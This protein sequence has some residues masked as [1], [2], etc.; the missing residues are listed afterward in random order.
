M[1][2]ATRTQT[3]EEWE[4][5]LDAMCRAT[6]TTGGTDP[7]GIGCDL[8]AGHKGAHVITDPFGT[9]TGTW[10]WSF[11]SRLNRIEK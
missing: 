6:R 3:Y 1:N 5:E 10:T 11:G 9:D 7:Y 4:A 2:T 8:P